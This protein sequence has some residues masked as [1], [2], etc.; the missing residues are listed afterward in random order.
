M[1]KT[2][3][4]YS[5]IL[6]AL[7]AE[8][9]ST[10]A[11]EISFAREE[12]ARFAAQ[13]DVALPKNLGDVVYSFRYRKSLPDVITRTA[14]GGYEWIIR[15]A[16]RGQYRLVLAPELRIAPALDAVETKLLDA[17]PGIIARYAMSDE[18][19]L[20]AR[21]RYNRL[22]DVFTGLSCYSLQSHL[23]TTVANMGQVETD[24]IYVGVNREGA[25]FVLPVQAKGPRDRIGR[26]QIEQDVEMCRAKFPGAAC[27]PIAAQLMEPNK[28]ALFE[29]EDTP[30]GLRRRMER[31]YRLVPREDLSDADLA[32]Y[33]RRG[34]ATAE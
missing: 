33:R 17:T 29:F 26:V 16:G 31:Y 6:A 18:Q 1:P 11:T 27:R 13:F 25:H 32:R 24:E 3:D 19:A 7:F 4:R 20:L 12:F 2:A 34:E 10:G 30:D 9:Y 14:P 21:L 15:P 5:Q 28:V 8:K 22:I 23:R